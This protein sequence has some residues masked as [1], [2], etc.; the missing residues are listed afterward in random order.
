M[1]LA[2][3]RHGKTKDKNIVNHKDRNPKNN[4]YKN[5]EWTDYKGNSTHAMGKKIKQID[6]KTNK[7]I[8]EFDSIASAVRTLGLPK[9]RI[10][11][12]S[13][14]CNKKTKTSCGFKWEFV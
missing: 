10:P 6:I 5:L 7:V 3:P 4:Y 8:N 14:C 2:K 12:I 1:S 11:A 9:S 13:N